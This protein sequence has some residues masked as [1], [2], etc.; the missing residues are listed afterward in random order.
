MFQDMI[1]HSLLRGI[2]LARKEKGR[3]CPPYL[4]LYSWQL[5]LVSLNPWL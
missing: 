3:G 5:G 4:L 2:Y 1:L